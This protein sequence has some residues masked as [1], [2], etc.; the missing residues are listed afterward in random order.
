MGAELC[1]DFMVL[2]AAEARRSNLAGYD[3][4]PVKKKLVAARSAQFFK[5]AYLFQNFF[6]KELTL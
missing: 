2:A 1:A 5:V 3:A 6:S 4:S